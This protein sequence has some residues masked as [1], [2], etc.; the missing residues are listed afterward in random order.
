VLL[1]AGPAPNE[2]G[3]SVDGSGGGPVQL[4]AA[5]P[6]KGTAPV[7]V[8]L[9]VQPWGAATPMMVDMLCICAAG[10]AGVSPP[11]EVAARCQRLA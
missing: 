9:G 8:L 6:G 10:G 2:P 3:V 1:T 7:F 4:P 11:R 5:K